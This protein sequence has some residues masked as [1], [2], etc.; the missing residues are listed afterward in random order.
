MCQMNIVLQEGEKEEI[1]K[2]DITTLEV[3]ENALRVST[4]F[5]GPTELNN[6]AIRKIDFS[7][8]KVILEKTH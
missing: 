4:L 7:G 8:G 3:L 1:L 5:E 6:M 2:E